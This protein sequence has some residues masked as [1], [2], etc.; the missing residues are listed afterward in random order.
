AAD[1][2]PFVVDTVLEMLRSAM[3]EYEE[4]IAKGRI[5]KPV[6]YQDSR[7]FVWQAEKL[8]GSVAEGIGQKD[9]EALKGAQAAFADLKKAWPAPVQPK[10][11]VRDV[12]QVLADV[13]KIEL[14]LGR[15]R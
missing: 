14:Q 15:F 3:G 13:S 4:A 8:F 12:S 7:G 5:A 1:W 10:T 6:E 2:Q 9:A 11:P